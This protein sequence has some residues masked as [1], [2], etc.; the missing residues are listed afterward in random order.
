MSDLKHVYEIR[1]RKD[2]RGVD[3]PQICKRRFFLSYSV[4][5]PDSSSLA[6]CNLDLAI[7]S[8]PSNPIVLMPLG[9]LHLPLIFSSP[10]TH[11]L[12]FTRF[13]DRNENFLCCHVF[14]YRGHFLFLRNIPFCRLTLRWTTNK[15]PIQ[16]PVIRSSNPPRMHES[17][18]PVQ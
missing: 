10:L 3:L 14:I 13:S 2:K 11:L 7:A 1:Q 9:F 16:C 18:F 17:P 6:S 15:L 8:F 12:R 4:A 5:A